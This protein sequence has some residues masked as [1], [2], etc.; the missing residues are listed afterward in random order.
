MDKTK[1]AMLITVALFCLALPFFALAHNPRLVGDES[2]IQIK[3]PETS[4]SFYGEL[5]NKSQYFN[6]NAKDPFN[7]YVNL[8]VPDKA[9]IET[10]I[11]AEVIKVKDGKREV[12]SLLDGSKFNWTRFYEPF[13]SDYYLRGPEFE[14]QV[15]ASEYIIHVFGL[16]QN[17]KYVLVVGKKESS[18]LG[19]IWRSLKTLPVIKKDFFGKSPWTA[20]LNYI[21]L[22]LLVVV[23]ILAI[24]IY[25]VCRLIKR[26]KT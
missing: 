5:A 11:W 10:R 17:E 22:M 1:K 4:Q 23:L 7:L 9:G 26:H 8:L 14:A 18:A 6:I 2:K 3:N 16:K 21:G 15:P 12:I 13:G 19:E 20:Y 24:A 25:L